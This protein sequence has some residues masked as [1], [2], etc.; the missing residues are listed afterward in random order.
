MSA[1][2]M[3]ETAAMLG[4]DLHDYITIASVPVPA[5]HLVPVYSLGSP[6]D[7]ADQK[8]STVTME[9][10]LVLKGGATRICTLHIPV[11]LPPVPPE[12]ILEAINLAAIIAESEAVMEMAAHK[13]TAQ[14]APLAT[15][16]YRTFGA[17]R[18]CGD[19]VGVGYTCHPNSVTTQPTVGDYLGALAGTLASMLFGWLGGLLGDGLAKELAQFVFELILRM[20]NVDDL[21]DWIPSPDSA[22]NF[23]QRWIDDGFDEAQK[24]WQEDVKKAQEEREKEKAEEDQ[25][26]KKRLDHILKKLGF[27]EVGGGKGGTK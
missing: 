5:I 24:Q 10:A 14:G 18:D 21:L 4:I 3:K 9:G 13:V 26:W 23:V 1:N 25:D 19:P 8:T 12:P 15:T 17:I 6:L 16:L 11:P 2:F 27:R 20:L 7:E 22:H